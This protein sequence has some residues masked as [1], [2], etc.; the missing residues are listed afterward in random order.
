MNFN[1]NE[2]NSF[3]G[4]SRDSIVYLF[5]LA[6]L[7]ITLV[8]NF[9]LRK[10][11]ELLTIFETKKSHT[12]YITSTIFKVF[13]LLFCNN[14]AVLLITIVYITGFEGLEALFGINGIVHNIEL[15]M[16]WGL[17]SPFLWSLINPEQLW[18]EFMYRRTKNHIRNN[19]FS[20]KLM[21]QEANRLFEK[22]DFEFDYRYFSV[23]KTVSIALFFQS[24]IPFGVLI[25]ALEMILYYVFDFISI[26]KF[27][28]RPKRYDFHLT[29]QILTFFD[30]C[31]IFLPLGYI[32]FYEYFLSSDPQFILYLCLVLTII[33]AII[34]MQILFFCCQK[35]TNYKTNGILYSDFKDM[36]LNYNQSNP[37]TANF[38]L[39]DFIPLKKVNIKKKI[40]F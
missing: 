22:F 17:L 35:C 8:T 20:N 24:I 13:I 3:L 32:I 11:V 37:S 28:N 29:I 15:V 34:N 2:I 36:V 16:V 38:M 31:L 39:I 9:V 10:I 6:I 18:K 19:K 27:C 23:F 33:E 7:I 12:E 25:A 21:Q 40:K 26:T 1:V 4:F 14:G 30:I 5:D